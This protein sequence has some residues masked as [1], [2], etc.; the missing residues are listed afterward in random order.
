ML[1]TRPVTEDVHR[2]LSTPT[3]DTARSIAM[4]ADD[5]VQKLALRTVVQALN[6]PIAYINYTR[7]EWSAA[8]TVGQGW[9]DAGDEVSA[10]DMTDEAHRAQFIADRKFTSK[11]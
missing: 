6:I 10:Y 1:H 11:A 7:L 2:V 3:F 5:G 8:D 9:I 4:L